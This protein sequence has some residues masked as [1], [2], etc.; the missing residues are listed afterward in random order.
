M[1]ALALRCKWL[2]R[3]TRVGGQR[4]G[5]DSAPP[6]SRWPPELGR[7][8]LRLLWALCH[9]RALMRCCLVSWGSSRA[10][11]K[12][13]VTTIEAISLLISARWTKGNNEKYQ[14]FSSA[15]PC[16]RRNAKGEWNCSLR[17]M[18][19]TD[20]SPLGQQ[21]CLA[22]TV[23]DRTL[24]SHQT[25]A[26]IQ[27]LISTGENIY[28]VQRPRKYNYY[29]WHRQ[30]ARFWWWGLGG[31]LSRTSPPETSTYR[32]PSTTRCPS[33]TPS[34]SWKEQRT[35][36]NYFWKERF[37]NL[38]SGYHSHNEWPKKIERLD[39]TN[40]GNPCR[41]VHYIT[42]FIETLEIWHEWNKT[43]NSNIFTHMVRIRYWMQCRFKEVVSD[44]DTKVVVLTGTDP[45]Y[46]AGVNLSATI[47]PMHPKKLHDMIYTRCV[48]I[49]YQNLCMQSFC[50]TSNRAVFDQFLDCPK[51]II[52]GA[53]GPAIGACVTSATL[54]DAIVASEQATFLTPFARLALGVNIDAVLLKFLG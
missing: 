13:G 44:P 11:G 32:P 30:Q 36:W 25:L 12:N 35:R 38:T 21:L 37:L 41:K 16:D 46:C 28:A 42:N 26:H 14:Y 52:I 47:Q 2:P 34:W 50:P 27:R 7:G 43:G 22:K 53:N 18:K 19:E 15:W 20:N 49:N 4:P 33:P 5:K 10:G 29:R 51:P 48:R 24:F 39:W 40:D 54:C 23:C 45:Y 9:W 17:C 1:D 8:T 31:S 3:G 6:W